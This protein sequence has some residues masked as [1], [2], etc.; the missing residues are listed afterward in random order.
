V[1][2]LVE[3]EREAIE[4]ALRAA[5]GKLGLAAGMLGID[6]ST[7]WRKL[8]HGSAPRAMNGGR[9]PSLG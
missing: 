1:R 8:Q 3:V 7:L 9:C 6:R 5:G 2:T 4:Q